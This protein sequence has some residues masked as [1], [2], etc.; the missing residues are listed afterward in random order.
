MDP[1]RKNILSGPDIPTVVTYSHH[2]PDHNRGTTFDT[3]Y[4]L[5]GLD[6]LTLG[7][8]TVEPVHTT[9]RTRED[10]TSY[11]IAY[12]GFSILHLGD[13]QGSIAR[14]D[15]E[16]MREHLKG[17]FAEPID[18]LL[19]PIG[20]TQDIVREAEATVALLQPQRVIPMHYWNAQE[21]RRFLGHL[22]A[23]NRTVGTTYQ[24]KEIA[25]AEYDVWIDEADVTPV[26]VVS[27]EPA[28]F[29]VPSAHTENQE[30]STLQDHEGDTSI[31]GVLSALSSL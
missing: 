7:D 14:I 4:V 24:G 28:P 11:R 27:L 9:E 12:K 13:A 30:G 17:I 20:W 22:A 21:K 18:L 8:I 31:A 25:S 1:D 2:H 5:D 23:Q 3:G 6:A 15:H 16:D 10:N 29:N 26:Q 19:L